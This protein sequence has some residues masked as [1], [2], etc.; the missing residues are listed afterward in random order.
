LKR[1][2]LN[3][4]VSVCFLAF[5]KNCI[6][7]FQLYCWL[8]LQ[9]SGHFKLTNQLVFEGINQLQITK[10]TFKKRL[11]WLLNQRWIGFN[12]KTGSYHINSFKVL[13][14]RTGWTQKTGI[15]WEDYNIKKF[16][17]FVFA[18]ILY[19]IAKSKWWYERQLAKEKGRSVIKAGAIKARSSTCIERPS[20]SL[21][22][23]YIAKKLNKP[24][25][26]INGLK[27]AAKCAGFIYIKHQKRL[28]KTKSSETFRI[29]KT[30]PEKGRFFVKNGKLYERLTDKIIFMFHAK[31]IRSLKQF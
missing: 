10:P 19:K 28:V 23:H 27:L 4:P 6:A 26:T 5:Q 13:H 25:A 9:C 14:Y 18:A 20:F 21:P 17:E 11:S 8:K 7:E 29:I 2:Y 22:L 31:R 15:V 12:S 1:N 24:V 30:H 3:I 16:K